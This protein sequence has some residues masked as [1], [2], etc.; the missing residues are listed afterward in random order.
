MKKSLLEILLKST[1]RTLFFL[2]NYLSLRLNND[3][4]LQLKRKYHKE[5]VFFHN[6]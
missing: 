4:N 6:S 2:F 3:I 5:G 1:R